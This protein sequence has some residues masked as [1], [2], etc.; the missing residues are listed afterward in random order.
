MLTLDDAEVRAG[1]GETDGAQNL[2]C[3]ETFDQYK[4]DLWARGKPSISAQPLPVM[5]TVIL[6]FLMVARP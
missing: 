2:A 5:N 1:L 6:I 3:F 4:P